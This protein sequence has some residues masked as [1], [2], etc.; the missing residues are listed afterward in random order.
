VREAADLVEKIHVF[1]AGL[2]DRAIEWLK[3]SLTRS[4]AQASTSTNAGVELMEPRFVRLAEAG[5][6]LH[7]CWGQISSCHARADAIPVDSSSQNGT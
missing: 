6:S 3:C 7:R 1:D 5:A 2:D 4:L